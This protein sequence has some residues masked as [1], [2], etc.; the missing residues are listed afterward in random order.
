M[1]WTEHH[2]NFQTER[3]LIKYKNIEWVFYKGIHRQNWNSERS[4]REEGELGLPKKV[5]N[6]RS[7]EVKTK[8]L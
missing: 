6:G 4:V 3:D 8:D 2:I 1:R 7:V 5:R